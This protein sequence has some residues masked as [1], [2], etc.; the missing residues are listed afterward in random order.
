MLRRVSNLEGDYLNDLR[1]TNVYGPNDEKLGTLSDG[2]MD[3]RTGDLRYLVVDAGWLRSRRFL[4][5]AD[6]VYAYGDGNDLYANLQQADVETLPEF[7]DDLLASDA[8]FANYESAY[9]G[10][11]RY[12]IDPTRV[13]TSPSLTRFR[14]RLRDG[15]LHS[16]VERRPVASESEVTTIG[17]RPTN[18]YGIFEDRKDVEK[19]VDRLRNDG[20]PSA[21]ISVVFPDRDMNKEF[22][23]EKNT[24]APE[25]ALAGGG[26]GLLLGGA[27]GW[28]VGIGTLAIPGV[29]PLIAAG[30]IVA[31]LAGAGVG[32]A[33]GGIAGALIGLGVP[34]LEAKQFE[35]ELKRGRI[36]ISVRCDSVAR[37]HAVRTVLED[38]G[39]KDVFLS[40]EQRAA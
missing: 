2:L 14:E 24:K 13:R 27:L 10:G 8:T 6:R 22:A 35:E 12:D 21:D 4:L 11:W 30:P 17:A 39:G 20:F 23:I 15:R 37:A 9:R 36:L 19:A 40:G 5:P 34:E 16:N 38:A 1:G 7:N 26:T 31:A 3:D 32:S 29:G 18:V 25:G 28:L 33:V